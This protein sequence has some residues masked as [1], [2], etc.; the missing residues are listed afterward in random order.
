M[1]IS[2]ATGRGA[3]QGVSSGSLRNRDSK[4]QNTT[5]A[6]EKLGNG[7]E[8]ASPDWRSSGVLLVVDDEP[9]VRLVM[10]TVLSARGFDVL[11]AEDGHQ[12]LR[13]FRE[14]RDD[15]R[16]VLLDMSMPGMDGAETSRELHRLR[17]EIPVVLLS[18]L[19][20]RD[21][22]DFTAG[23]ELAGFLPKPFK[24]AALVDKVREVLEGS[25]VRDAEPAS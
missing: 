24:P 20:E 19:N 9:M 11:E 2:E 10:T 22:V 6:N 17:P 1:R 25:A 23:T 14:R 13:I 18:G 8:R 15:I 21:T 16:A 7:R 12:A 5:T 4:V 3:R